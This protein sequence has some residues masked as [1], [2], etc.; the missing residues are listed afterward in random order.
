MR[1]VVCVRCEAHV[2]SCEVCVMCRSTQEQA[3][4]EINKLKSDLAEANSRIS[5]LVKEGD[6]R[7]TT[8]EKSRDRD[9]L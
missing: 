7:H 8:L 1:C 5:L 2:C 3:T 9:L 6:E 4:A